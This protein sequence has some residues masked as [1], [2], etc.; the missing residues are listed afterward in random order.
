MDVEVYA[1]IACPWCRLG[2]YRFA[3]AVTSL[4]A[5]DV[6]VVY[7]PFQLN[8]HAPETPRPALDVMAGIFGREQAEAMAAD[9][10]RLGAS[11]GLEYRY[12]R[13]MSVNTLAAHRL[14]WRTLREQ[15]AGTQGRLA[16]ALYDAYFRD[17]RNVADH[18][19]LAEVAGTVGLDGAGVLDYLASDEDAD[20]V[21][22]D[23]AQARQDGIESVPTFVFPGGEILRGESRTEVLV[24]ALTRSRNGE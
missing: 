8:P 19:V 15:G 6:S 23:V 21:R 13:T 20:D 4:D 22:R 17:G 12:D 2:T 16:A 7:R 11:D 3:R 1:D 5:S 9:M 24:A 18:A 10:T 14:L